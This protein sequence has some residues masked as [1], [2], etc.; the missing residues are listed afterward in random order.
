MIPNFIGDIFR[1]GKG[2]GS[3]Y[4]QQPPRGKGK[5]NNGAATN[6]SGSNPSRDMLKRNTSFSVKNAKNAGPNLSV[7]TKQ[8]IKS[9]CDYIH[10]FCSFADN[11]FDFDEVERML[12]DPIFVEE[13]DVKS[14]QPLMNA[15]AN[16]LRLIQ[17]EPQDWFDFVLRCKGEGTESMSMEDFTHE[18]SKLCGQVGY[19]A[20]PPADVEKLFTF[21]KGNRPTDDFGVFEL[22]A[23]FTKSRLPM[24]KIRAVNIIASQLRN[25]ST[26]LHE[27]QVTLRD[28]CNIPPDDTSTYWVSLE[29]LNVI[30]ASILLRKEAHEDNEAN[31]IVS[32]DSPSGKSHASPSGRSSASPSKTSGTDGAIVSEIK[33]APLTA[34]RENSSLSPGLG[35]SKALSTSAMDQRAPLTLKQKSTVSSSPS[36]GQ[37]SAANVSP[38]GKTA[39]VKAE[40]INGKEA[41][42]TR[43]RSFLANVTESVLRTFGSTGTPHGEAPQKRQSF[44]ALKRNSA[45]APD[46][47]GG[48]G[49]DTEQTESPNSINKSMS[50]NGSHS[51]N[52][53]SSL[54]NSFFDAKQLRSQL[55]HFLRAD[56]QEQIK[57]ISSGVITIKHGADPSAAI[58]GGLFSLDGSST[59]IKNLSAKSAAAVKAAQEA[60]KDAAAVETATTDTHTAP[61]RRY[62]SLMMSTDS[63]DDWGDDLLDDPDVLDQLWITKHKQHR[64]HR[65]RHLQT[66]PSGSNLLTVNTDDGA[67]VDGAGGDGNQSVASKLSLPRS[68]GGDD[69]AASGPLTPTRPNIM[70]REQSA[71]LIRQLSTSHA[72]TTAVGGGG[73]SA[74]QQYQK[75]VQSFDHRVG[76]AQRMV[77]QQLVR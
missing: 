46:T 5:G 48:G 74:V 25:L 45:I 29:D 2:N 75:I 17:T 47:T 8:R 38:N 68:T 63:H 16:I 49:G 7:A 37:S 50:S 35:P 71:A 52:S 53:R 69:P 30:F 15:F 14:M 9:F 27:T 13:E 34:E 55:A 61:R 64:H 62:S 20:F 6:S 1:G 3:G 40:S 73:H 44:F 26:F 72:N 60:A 4:G 42:Q 12:R 58:Q 56:E 18:L 70:S 28:I 66:T 11:Q 32:C 65:H 39:A 67:G 21:I 77:Q 33:S 22:A 10:L 54:R 23:A 59:S 41:T 24:P 51:S 57:H 43:K 31:S 36:K 76:T 19:P